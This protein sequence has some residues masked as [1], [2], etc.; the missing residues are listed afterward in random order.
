MISF[1]VWRNERQL[2][3]LTREQIDR[4]HEISLERHGGMAG[5]GN[6]GLIESALAAAQSTFFYGRG[7]VFD[8]AAAYAF[9]IAETQAF[10][11]GNKRTAAS[12]ALTFLELNGVSAT[13]TEDA[14]YSAMI[15]IA[16]K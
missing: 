12:T 3:F 14:L 15:D 4:L 10:I 9:H 7:D 11:D 1:A 13:P 8:I 6:E 2:L 16:N 5:V